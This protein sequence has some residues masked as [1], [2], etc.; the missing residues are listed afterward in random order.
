MSTSSVTPQIEG[1]PPGASVKPI[2][3]VEG[4]PAGAVVKPIQP[5]GEQTN[6]IGKTVIVPKD[7][8]SF[9]DT[10]KRAAEHGKSVTP[11]D[12]NDEMAT[13][14]GKAA[15]VLGAAPV[16]GAAGTAALAGVG[17]LALPGGAQS[18]GQ[19]G[20]RIAKSLATLD[21]V[22]K[23][24]WAS[25]VLKELGISPKHLTHLIGLVGEE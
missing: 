7:G 11:Q 4:L 17:S 10:M 3:Q 24:A 12:I 1:L 20:L 9:Q 23:A 25:L 15:A 21:N 8:E 6:D 14:P 13:A 19:A 18:I 22:K 2:Q 5:E 16:M